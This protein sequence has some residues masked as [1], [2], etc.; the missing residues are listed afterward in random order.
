MTT[1]V[2]LG[3]VTGGPRLWASPLFCFYPFSRSLLLSSHSLIPINLLCFSPRSMMTLGSPPY[4]GH[5]LFMVP[6]RCL[7]PPSLHQ[8]HH[9]IPVIVSDDR[10]NLSLKFSCLGQ[11]MCSV[12]NNEY[13]IIIVVFTFCTCKTGPML[14]LPSMY[15]ITDQCFVILN[16]Q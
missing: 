9:T 7:L 6:S 12:H 4:S 10:G 1:H 3:W 5:P 11:T 14:L 13:P 15:C 2:L 8:A 16:M